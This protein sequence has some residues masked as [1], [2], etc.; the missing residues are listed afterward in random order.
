MQEVAE[1]AD[2]AMFML[3]IFYEVD[4]MQSVATGVLRG[5]GK[6]KFTCLSQLFSYYLV[7][8]ILNYYFGFHLNMGLLGLWLGQTISATIDAGFKLYLAHIKYKD[9]GLTEKSDEI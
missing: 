8:M 1:Q 6:F 7:A 9:L 2:S 3:A 5:L 4:M